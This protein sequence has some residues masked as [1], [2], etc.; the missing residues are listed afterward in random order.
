MRILK[1]DATYLRPS[2]DY[3][4]PHQ[5]LHIVVKNILLSDNSFIVEEFEKSYVN[6][7]LD[8]RFEFLKIAA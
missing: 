8:L 5:S 4:F 1:E 2:D 3:Y 7:Y 6:K